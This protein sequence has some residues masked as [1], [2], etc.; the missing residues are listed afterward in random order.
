MSWDSGWGDGYV[1]GAVL[2]REEPSSFTGRKGRGSGRRRGKGVG[3]V[4]GAQ[5]RYTV[6]A[7]SLD[8]LQPRRANGRGLGCGCS[9]KPAGPG[10]AIPVAR[11]LAEDWGRYLDGRGPRIVPGDRCSENT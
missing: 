1:A 5:G 7:A 11:R 4:I 10:R 2:G 8:D 6:P 3:L 9:E